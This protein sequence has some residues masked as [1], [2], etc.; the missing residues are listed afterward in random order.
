MRITF[1]GDICLN[2]KADCQSENEIRENFCD[3]LSY[4]AQGDFSVFNMENTYG[5][6]EDYEPIVKIG[7]NLLA[8]E[9]FIRY[10]KVLRPTV[11]NF[12]NNHT[13][14]FGEEPV[15]KTLEF[16]R[17]EGFLTIGAGA[18][19]EEAYRPAI[20]KKDG[21]SVAVIGVCENEFGIADK[22]KAGSAGFRLDLL[23]NEIMRAKAEGHKVVL[24][25]HAGNEHNPFPSPEKVA[26]YRH[27]IDF[28][29]TAVIAMHTHCPQPYEEYHGGVIVYSMGNFFFPI[30]TRANLGAEIR[31]W[32]YGYMSALEI[33]E[34]SNRVEIAPYTFT[35]NAQTFLQGEELAAFH[36]Y[37]RFTS[38]PLQDRKLLQEYFDAWCMI[39]G[40]PI[41]I[42]RAQYTEDMLNG[43]AAAIVKL[44]SIFSCEA[45][46]ELV[47]NTTKI[48]YE[49]RVEQARK[50]VP[51][52][53]KLQNMEC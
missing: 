15:K 53:H 7:P 10:A 44:K 8:D 34:N 40:E 16:F 28:G 14:D 47:K 39:K 17:R 43:G 50:Y 26:M 30:E 1:A 21:V 23:S 41:Y 49:G 2:Y 18:D 5:C 48:I 27:L 13:G 37:L 46:N 25:L 11:A 52:I 35:N 51:L 32:N 31:S 33:T 20:L 4:M 24:F 9:E 38:E 36:R 22:S 19:I 42:R 29:V 6:K 45:H 3:A 12:A